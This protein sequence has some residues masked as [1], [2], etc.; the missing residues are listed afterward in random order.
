MPLVQDIVNK[1]KSQ[2]STPTTPSGFVPSAPSP[3]PEV[4]ASTSNALSEAISSGIG[5]AVDNTL[6]EP[7]QQQ[8]Q[9]R[10]PLAQQP[11]VT[12]TSYQLPRIQTASMASPTSTE[13]SFPESE[14]TS[15]WDSLRE[16][17]LETARKIDEAMGK[18]VGDEETKASLLSPEVTIGPG[19]EYV[20][21]EGNVNRWGEEYEENPDGTWSGA[22][23]NTRLNDRYEDLFATGF[24]GE[25]KGM[26]GYELKSLHGRSGDN[27]LQHKG[28]AI[29]PMGTGVVD[30]GTLDYD[31]LTSPKILGSQLQRYARNGM[32]P[33]MTEDEIMQV[34][35]DRIYDKASLSLDEDVQFQPYI[36]DE[37]TWLDMTAGYGAET[38]QRTAGA[39]ANLR[40][41]IAAEANPYQIVLNDGNGSRRYNGPMFDKGAGGFLTN[42]Y[43]DLEFHP[44]RFFDDSH[45]NDGGSWRQ[46]ALEWNTVNPQGEVERHYGKITSGFRDEGNGNWSMDFSDGSTAVMPSSWLDSIIG[47][48]GNPYIPNNGM[49][50]VTDL[51]L[52]TLQMNGGVVPQGGTDENGNRYLAINSPD[53]YSYWEPSYVMDDGN[54]LSFADVNKIYFDTNGMEENEWLGPGEEIGY[55]FGKMLPLLPINLLSPISPTDLLT[56]KPSRLQGEPVSV[57]DG[58]LDLSGLLDNGF[59]RVA[60][61]T[62]GSLPI[63]LEETAWPMSV[64]GGLQ[65]LRYGV[66]SASYDPVTNSYSYLSGDLDG[67]GRIVPTSSDADRMI[68][69]AMSVGVPITEEA[70]GPIGDWGARN[71]LPGVRNRLGRFLLGTAAEGLEEIGGNFWDEVRTQGPRAFGDYLD[72]NGNVVATEAEAAKDATGRP[73]RQGANSLQ[74]LV[75]TMP[76]RLYNMGLPGIRDGQLSLQPD[77]LANNINGFI[78]GA[79]ISALPTALQEGMAARMDARDRA[80]LRSLYGIDELYNDP[81]EPSSLVIPDEYIAQWR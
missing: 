31:H 63:M 41:A 39:V 28:S 71:W 29:L 56:N 75:E 66:N 55:E 33:G 2:L 61:W 45:R 15:Y 72:E 54:Q 25:T 19:G 65:D 81:D 20:P 78:G 30:D 9:Q 48:D 32:A 47:D 34:N 57:N 46:Y 3:A 77:A 58:K 79:S 60:D 22:I 70:V 38:G 1:V 35:P 17:D 73:A 11:Q 36:P 23:G 67:N 52:D 7:Q 21:G 27:I 62:L 13:M 69:T 59:D 18:G 12:S 26:T 14:H 5:S 68:S 40:N 16:R 24:N 76:S 51:G 53:A 6:Q 44:E 8:T 37:R 10:R 49:V 80:L 50:D 74:E 64:S 43:R 42:V 4:P